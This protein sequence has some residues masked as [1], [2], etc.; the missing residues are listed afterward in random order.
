MGKENIL[1]KTF[2]SEN[3]NPVLRLD[4][5]G[6]VIYQNDAAKRMLKRFNMGTI[7]SL[8]PSLKSQA[9]RALRKKNDHII[10]EAGAKGIFYSFSLHPVHIQ[11]G[12]YVNIYGMDITGTKETEEKLRQKLDLLQRFARVAVAREERIIELKKKISELKERLGAR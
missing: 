8:I 6:D 10:L 5:K 3:P 12:I 9:G 11:D 1:T 2:P 7:H 4:R